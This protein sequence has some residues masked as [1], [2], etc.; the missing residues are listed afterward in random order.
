M[1]LYPRQ[2][3]PDADTAARGQSNLSFGDDNFS[4]LQTLFYHDLSIDVHSGDDR[5]RFDCLVGLYHENKGSVLAR[6]HCLAWDHQG[7]RFRS[8]SKNNPDK[9]ARPK[10]VVLIRER[11]LDKDR[12]G[13]CIDSI[14]DKK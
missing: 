13:R 1:W 2:Y 9:L 4:G 12:S 11:C 7:V 10:R 6:L 14:V 3:S 8:Q 5:T